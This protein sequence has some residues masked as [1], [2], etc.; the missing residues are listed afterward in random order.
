MIYCTSAQSQS[1]RCI[2]LRRVNLP[3]LSYW[4]ESISLQYI[5]AQSQSPAVSYCAESIS[6]QYHT[7]QS[8]SPCR[9]ILGRVNLPAVSKCAESISLQYHTAQSWS[10]R[11]VNL[12]AVLQYTAQS[13][14]PCNTILRRVNHPTVSYSAEFH[15]NKYEFLLNLYLH[16][17]FLQKSSRIIFFVLSAVLW[18]GVESVFYSKIWINNFA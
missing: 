7:A 16:I 3:A 6:P 13:Q 5:T 14:S 18:Y 11:R 15:T 2:I 9:I 8:Q 10:P 4:A 1:P 12:P 17:A